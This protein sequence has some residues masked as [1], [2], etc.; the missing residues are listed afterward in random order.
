GGAKEAGD[1][2]L[3]PVDV[4]LKD[5]DAPV[6]LLE[7][8]RLVGIIL[9]HGRRHHLLERD[10]HALGDGCRRAENVES[11]IGHRSLT[12]L[13]LTPAGSLIAGA[14]TGLP[15]GYVVI[16]A[17]DRDAGE[18]AELLDVLLRPAFDDAGD[19][20]V[21]LDQEGRR[22]RG[23][24]VGVAGGE[25]VLLAVEQGGER[26]AELAVE[27]AGVLLAVLRDAV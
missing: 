16:V 12:I 25:L 7:L 21:A 23:D 14:S 13:S 8:G 9:G 10:A 24:A 15:G 2:L 22:D 11:F 17:D 1:A 5:V 20:A 26:D 6:A 27:V 19:R 4:A 3:E 18:S